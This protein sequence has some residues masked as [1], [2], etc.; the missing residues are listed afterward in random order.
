MLISMHAVGVCLHERVQVELPMCVSHPCMRCDIMPPFG[1][2]LR[3]TSAVI[4]MTLRTLCCATTATTT[5][6]EYV[7]ASLF[8]LTH[9]SSKR[10]GIALVFY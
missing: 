8:G 6:H 1:G 10:V 4:T 7:L 2:V 9:T 3:A 5:R